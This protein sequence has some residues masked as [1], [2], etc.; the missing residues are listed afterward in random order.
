[1]LSVN[2]ER[3]GAR[4]IYQKYYG[5]CPPIAPSS[6]PPGKIRLD[7]TSQRGIE[8]DDCGIFRN[9]GGKPGG[10][11]PWRHEERSRGDSKQK[12]PSL[13]RWLFSLATTP[14]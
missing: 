12:E 6:K 9:C 3:P 13:P 7:K 10:F 1:L 8:R 4:T 11:R 2:R 14:R 5:W